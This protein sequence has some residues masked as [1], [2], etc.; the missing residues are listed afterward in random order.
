MSAASSKLDGK[1]ILITGGCGFLGS[2]LAKRCLDLG[3]S[4]VVVVDLVIE[5]RSY[6]IEQGLDTRA[7]YEVCNIGDFEHIRSVI[8]K[9]NINIVFHLAAQAIVDAAYDD[10]LGTIKTNVLGTTNVLEA[11]RLY[12]KVESILVTST[13]KAY[14][15]LP[16]VSEKNPISGDHPYEVSKTSAD[17]IAESYFKT[18]KLPIVVTRFGNVYGEGD[19]NFSRIIP[20]IMAA[21]VNKK[22]FEIRSD[23][24]YVRDYVYVDDVIDA[25]LVLNSK[26]KSVQGEAFNISSY[27]NLSVIEVVEKVENISGEKIKYKILSSA[28]N[29]IP[30]QSVNFNKIKSTLGWSPKRNFNKTIPGI[31]A[32]YKNYFS[33]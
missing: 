12:G 29:E 31:L 24:K 1:N 17:L 4:K 26:I 11:C 9:H 13:D 10:P 16:R 19:I 3:A 5:P 20:G 32:W 33:I 8:T 23:G 27:E 22:P 25:A 30:K 18:Y 2:H 28:I 15:K 6:F 21:L 14:G 7:T